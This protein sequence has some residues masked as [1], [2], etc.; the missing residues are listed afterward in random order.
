MTTDLSAFY[1]DVRKDR[2]YCDPA[3]SRARHAALT[4]IDALFDCLVCWL[5]PMIPFTCDEAWTERHGGGSTVH[6]ELFPDVPQGWRNPALEAKWERVHRLRR[7]VLGA[8]E[9]VRVAKKIGSSLEAKAVLFLSDPELVAALE[10]VDLAEVAITSGFELR[11]LWA[12]PRQRL[13]APRREGRCGCR[14]FRRR[15]E[16]RALVE[17]FGGG[18]H[19]SGLSRRHTSRRGGAPRIWRRPTRRIMC[20]AMMRTSESGH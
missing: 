1:F 19:R 13:P 6:L 8:L 20:R 3:S 14:C 2:L 16:V 4:V 9:E 18:R 17:V 12:R 11:P 10:G 15:A 5:A 7:V